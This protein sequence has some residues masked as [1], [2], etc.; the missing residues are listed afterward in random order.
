MAKARRFAEGGDVDYVSET[1]KMDDESATGLTP[2][3]AE[4]EAPKKQSFKE[5]FAAARK[6]GGKTFEWNG[7]K[8]TTDLAAPKPK[9]KA[10]SL[11]DE[12]ALGA[13]NIAGIKAKQ[14][15]NFKPLKTGDMD[16]ADF[17]KR[18]FG[19]KPATF[20]KGGA[21]RGWGKA[22]GARAARYV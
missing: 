2:K 18:A 5:A 22:R 19:K 6:G 16:S 17:A 21:V 1:D 3:A 4:A 14:A 13:K 15:E 11:A 9:A 7:K 10:P 12:E 8:F 20:K